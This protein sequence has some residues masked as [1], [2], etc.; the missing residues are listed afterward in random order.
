[1]LLLAVPM[2][3]VYRPHS[4]RHCLNR[5]GDMLHMPTV[6]CQ[7]FTVLPKRAVVF[8]QPEENERAYS[9]LCT[10]SSNP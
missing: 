6:V 1:M 3:L 8:L 10:N 2:K 4:K 7:T 5:C 9:K